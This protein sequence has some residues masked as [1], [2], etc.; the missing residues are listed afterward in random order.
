M[1]SGTVIAVSLIPGAIILLNLISGR[2]AQYLEKQKHY[3]PS[4]SSSGLGYGIPNPLI[5]HQ[6]QQQYH[7]QPKQQKHS[8]LGQV[9]PLGYQNPAA[10]SGYGSQRRPSGHMV[11]KS[12]H[13]QAGMQY[14]DAGP[15]GYG[16][17]GGSLMGSPYGIPVAAAGAGSMGS[18]SYGPKQQKQHPQRSPYGFRT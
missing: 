17:G 18:Q 10:A 9:S 4:S 5:Q 8:A 14:E 3:R 7:R 15:A 2:D 11:K 13:L 6:Q 12:K 1:K 16:G